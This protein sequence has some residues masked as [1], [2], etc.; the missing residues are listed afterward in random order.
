MGYLKVLDAGSYKYVF[1][2]S[3]FI[4]KNDTNTKGEQNG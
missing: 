3:R 1:E 4:N 2:N